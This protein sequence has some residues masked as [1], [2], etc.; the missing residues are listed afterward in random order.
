MVHPHTVYRTTPH[1]YF[2]FELLATYRCYQLHPKLHDDKDTVLCWFCVRI[3]VHHI[4]AEGARGLTGRVHTA[5]TWGDGK[6]IPPSGS[7]VRSLVEVA[8][9]SLQSSRKW[10]PSWAP[11][12]S[13]RVWAYWELT[14]GPVQFPLFWDSWQEEKHVQAC[15]TPTL[16]LLCT[17]QIAQFYDCS[18]PQLPRIW[19]R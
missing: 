15:W 11:K 16:V 6:Y 4:T 7:R 8:Q 19:T 18:H 9:S 10:T 14:T 17:F 12:I 5:A 1:C 3:S 13:W 2:S